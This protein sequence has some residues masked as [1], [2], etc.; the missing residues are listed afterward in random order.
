VEIYDLTGQLLESIAFDHNDVIAGKNL[1][2]GIYLAKVE[3]AGQ[4]TAMFKL[5][6]NH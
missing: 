6:K 3:V 1:S 4:P 2:E 5:I